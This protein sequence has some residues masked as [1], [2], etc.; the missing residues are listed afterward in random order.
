VTAFGDQVFDVIEHTPDRLTELEDIGAKRK[1]VTSAWAEQKV[2]REIMV[3][4]QS[5][6]VGTTRAVRIYNTGI[7][8]SRWFVKTPIAWP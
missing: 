8:P 6:E 4:L 1:R 3:F 5:H 2:V 7:R